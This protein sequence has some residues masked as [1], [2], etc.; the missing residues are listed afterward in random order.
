MNVDPNG[1]RPM[2]YWA[3]I[4]YDAIHAGEPPVMS[5]GHYNVPTEYHERKAQ[6]ERYQ[7][8]KENIKP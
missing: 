3:G 7:K 4:E 2:E 1:P 6:E 5:K 8:A